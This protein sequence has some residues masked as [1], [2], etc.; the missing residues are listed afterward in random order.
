MHLPHIS[1]I[2]TA[3]NGLPIGRAR[4]EVQSDAGGDTNIVSHPLKRGLTHPHPPTPP[5][6]PSF[7]HHALCVP[8]LKSWFGFTKSVRL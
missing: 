1:P 2:H 7:V 3:Y 4:I 6:H 5:M 8:G